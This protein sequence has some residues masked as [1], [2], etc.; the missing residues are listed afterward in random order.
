MPV[1]VY[2]SRERSFC[3]FVNFLASSYQPH[4]SMSSG[5]FKAVTTGNRCLWKFIFSFTTFHR[6]VYS[7]HASVTNLTR[8]N[9]S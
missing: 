6:M 5:V 1:E 7:C 8:V 4:R 9:H 3:K 2:N